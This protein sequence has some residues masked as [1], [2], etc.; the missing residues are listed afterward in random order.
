MTETSSGIVA[1]AR[2]LALYSIA[3]D[4]GRILPSALRERMWTPPLDANGKPASYAYGWWVQDW[5]GRKLVWHGGWW[6]DYVARLFRR[7]AARF[8]ASP[9]NSSAAG[10][11]IQEKR[12]EGE[13]RPPPLNCSIP[14]PS[15]PTG[16]GMR[17]IVGSRA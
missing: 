6:P 9:A 13:V 12:W 8:A 4:E 15:C 3:L 10:S 17:S 5:R 1:S 16:S 11:V 14:P 2:E 7:G